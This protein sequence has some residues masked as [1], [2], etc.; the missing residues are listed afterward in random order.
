MTDRCLDHIEC[1]II[2]LPFSIW[3]LT[4]F[5][6]NSLKTLKVNFVLLLLTG[7]LI[8]YCIVHRGQ[9]PWF[10]EP[11][12]PFS[13]FMAY[14]KITCILGFCM[15]ESFRGLPFSEGRWCVQLKWRKKLKENS[16]KPMPMKSICTAEWLSWRKWT[17]S[18]RKWLRSWKGRRGSW[19]KRW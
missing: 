9:R 4:T 1:V 8:L 2:T 17:R 15:M 10:K 13:K 3:S 6:Q 14:D 5:Q 11:F 18:W 16:W 12:R 7:F 19:G